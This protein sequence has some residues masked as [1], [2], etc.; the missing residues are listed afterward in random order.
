MI[1]GAIEPG[2]DAQR[3]DAIG[4]VGHPPG[5][6]Q[7]VPKPGEDQQ[8]VLRRHDEEQSRF[9]GKWIPDLTVNRERLEAIIASLPE[10]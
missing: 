2:H 9:G 5:L 10:R 7:H 3:R 1:P 6:G 8:D 4:G